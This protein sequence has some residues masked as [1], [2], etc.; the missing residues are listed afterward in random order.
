MITLALSSIAVTL[1]VFNIR[2]AI[3]NL[4]SMENE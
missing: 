3:R 2:N 1:I 4:R